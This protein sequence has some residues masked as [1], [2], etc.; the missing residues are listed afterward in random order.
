MSGALFK[1]HPDKL[2]AVEESW[3]VKAKWKKLVLILVILLGYAFILEKLGYILSTFLL[4]S[5]L[6]RFVEAQRWLVTIAGSL[7]VSL[8]S[9]GVFDKW[10]K[11]QLPKG[12]W[13]SEGG[14]L[15]QY[16][17]GVFGCPPA[18]ESP[19]LFSGLRNGDHRRGSARIGASGGDLHSFTFDFS[20]EPRFSRHHA[21]GHLLWS[22]VWRFNDLHPG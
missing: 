19:A 9:Y 6:F 18:P 17:F 4:L 13:V 16:V 15:C 2:G 12:I 5:F 20:N 21:G 14:L 10:L 1:G 3:Y 7:M 8:V 22:H 11:M